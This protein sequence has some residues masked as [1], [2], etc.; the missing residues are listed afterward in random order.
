MEIPEKEYED[1]IK[2]LVKHVERNVEGWQIVEIWEVYNREE[3][4]PPKASGKVRRRSIISTCEGMGVWDGN[5]L[6]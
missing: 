3:V 1:Y 6:W 4:Q 5:V 2:A